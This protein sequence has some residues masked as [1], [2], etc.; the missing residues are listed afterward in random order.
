MAKENPLNPENT[1]P[2][3]DYFRLSK[4]NDKTVPGFNKKVENVT[5][6]LVRR[7]RS[8]T[9]RCRREQRAYLFVNQ[10]CIPGDTIPTVVVPLTALNKG[11]YDK[12]RNRYAINGDYYANRYCKKAINGGV[13]FLNQKPPTD[14][15]FQTIKGISDLNN[16]WLLM[17]EQTAN[18]THTDYVVCMGPR[19]MLRIIPA[20]IPMS[21]VI[22]VMSTTNPNNDCSFW[23]LVFPLTTSEK[24]KPTFSKKVGPGNFTCIKRI[25]TGVQLG[26]L[27]HSTC[28]NVIIMP[29]N[30]IPLYRGD[31]WWWC[32]DDRLFDRLPRGVTGYCALVTLL[33][34]VSVFPITV[35]GL[36]DK[37]S[38]IYPHR[39]IPRHKR[40]VWLTET[41]PT[42]IDAIGV[43]RGVPDEYKL[44]NQV[45][46]SW[47]SSICWW[48]TINKNV[49]RINY[50]HY[51][52]QKLGNWTQNRFEA[53]HEQLSATSLMAFQNR[54]ALD[55]LLAEKGG[56]C[57]MF[58]EQCCTF[59]PNNT[60]ADSRLTKAIEGL[61]TLND[62]M[63]GQYS[64][65]TTM[66]DSWLG[67][68]GKYRSLV[69]S[70]LVSIAVFMAILTL[71]GCC[72]IP[73]LRSSC[74]RLISTAITPEETKLHPLLKLNDDDDDD[75]DLNTAGLFIEGAV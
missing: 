66:W 26:K 20:F 47:E 21:C 42:Y 63:K 56:V 5:L 65:D 35:D 70:A 25:G 8:V 43:P 72:C 67:V 69:A 24:E 45:A 48:C 49:D 39:W 11:N 38:G 59:I 75:V 71:C 12:Y 37:L 18:A 32:G 52:V 46:A 28:K 62:K 30:F 74:N 9:D 27:N 53:V 36:V 10:I 50:I 1:T 14:E 16:N 68:F 4:L 34:P 7:Q 58:G 22:E 13:N 57:T 3:F 55:M 73:C 40:D 23:D 61:C 15:V 51:N 44:V 31:I 19:P 54:I 60:A 6:S 17:V 2:I 33:L 41:D 29:N 64:V